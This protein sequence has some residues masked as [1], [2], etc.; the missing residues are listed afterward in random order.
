M[1]SNLSPIP[2][3]GARPSG[4]GILRIR[5]WSNGR[6]F[7]RIWEYEVPEAHLDP[8]ITAYAADGAWAELFGRSR[9]HVGTELYRDR[10]S[11]GRFVT[12]DRW[13]D[14]KRWKSFLD[15]FQLAYQTFDNQ[16]EGLASSERPLFEGNL[17]SHRD[18]R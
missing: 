1:Q 4:D 12:I 6:V 18:A 16:L 15:E 13:V 9:G 14:E 3:F 5:M 17:T 7:V 11:G 10:A 2:A 8:F